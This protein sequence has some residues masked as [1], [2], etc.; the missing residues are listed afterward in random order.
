MVSSCWRQ[1]DHGATRS[2]Y[3]DEDI[4][5]HHLHHIKSQL[6]FPN[7][8]CRIRA[9][10]RHGHL[11][12]LLSSTNDALTSRVAHNGHIL[13]LHLSPLPDFDLAA[14]TEDAHT[15]GA[16]QVVRCVGVQVNT[17]VENSC[18]I[19][20]NSRGDESLATGVVLDEVGNVVD[21]TGNGDEGLAVLGLL[22]EVVP[23]NDGKLLEWESPVK[24]R[25]LLV[26]LLLLLL[27]AALL[28]LILAES[29]EVGG[30]AE[31]L[32]GPD[33][34]LGRVVLVPLDSVAVVGRELVVEVV[35]TFAEGDQCSDDVVTRAVPVVKRLL[36]EPVGKRVDAEGGLLNDEDT[37][38]SSVDEATP[39][40]TPA[41]TGNQG[42]ESQSHEENDLDEVGV[43]ED[44]DGILVKISDIGTTGTLGVL[45]DDHPAKV[46]VK[47]ALPDGVRVLLSVGI[48]VVS[49]VTL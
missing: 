32:P 34:P 40:V 8:L 33:A 31:L 45:L 3:R 4:P 5:A 17:T 10:H 41:E 20:S 2:W 24:L 27:K 49:A 44:N 23:V 38:D 30:E 25:A 26:E 28:D 42:G 37:E 46:A 39:P 29:L 12:G 22:N 9:S 13:V 21:D 7:H 36:A 1:P 19:L 6:I 16:K 43:L 35:V 48:S 14:S 18:G 47:Q 15:H 11:G